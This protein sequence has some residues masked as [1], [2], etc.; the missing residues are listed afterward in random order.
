MNTK[1]IL[2][3]VVITMLVLAAVFFFIF[4]KKNN[5]ANISQSTTQNDTKNAVSQSEKA[6]KP[7]NPTNSEIFSIPNSLADM[8][9]PISVSGML[10]K[11]PNSADCGMC[12]EG[13]CKDVLVCLDK[14]ASDCSSARGVVAYIV[15][16]SENKK[17]ITHL[18]VG[19]SNGKCDSRGVVTTA[20]ATVSTPSLQVFECL[21]EDGSLG[22][23]FKNSNAGSYVR[24]NC[25]GSFATFLKDRQ[26]QKTSPRCS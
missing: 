12:K 23:M 14:H 25:V 11:V 21:I 18:I 22:Q 2:F 8:K 6:E 10:E 17:V 7:K 16:N 5:S 13:D 26:S 9:E 1:K 3:A 24:D 4:Y 20:E 15:P 19:K